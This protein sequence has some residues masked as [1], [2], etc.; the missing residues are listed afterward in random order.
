ME[1]VLPQMLRTFFFEDIMLLL[2]KSEL[3]TPDS[4][5]VTLLSGSR[6]EMLRADLHVHAQVELFAVLR[7]TLT[8][9][10]ENERITLRK[11]DILFAAP[12]LKHRADFDTTHDYAWI[13]TRFTYE[14]VKSKSTLRLC[15]FLNGLFATEKRYILLR[16]QALI[17]DAVRRMSLLCKEGR[18]DLTGPLLYEIFLEMLEQHRRANRADGQPLL[19]SDTASMRVSLL[20]R[21][22]REQYMFPLNVSQLAR[23]MSL[24]ERQLERFARRQYGASLRDLVATERIAAAQTMLRTTSKTVQDIAFSVGYASVSCFYTAFKKQLGMT[25]SEF[26]ERCR[27]GDGRPGPGGAEHP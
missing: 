14:L 17:A 12:E 20:D 4:D 7:D 19:L 8:F 13:N 5:I 26:R 15:A 10:T 11:N 23:K 27:S 9:V 3:H 22:L 16:N 25:P 18:N 6:S 21:A 2:E 24:S 1:S